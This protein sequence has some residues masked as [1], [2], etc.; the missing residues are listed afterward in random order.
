MIEMLIEDERSFKLPRIVQVISLSPTL[1]KKV[2]ESC[3]YRYWTPK[4]LL[5]T[6]KIVVASLSNYKKK[7]LVSS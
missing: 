3:T 1:L 2:T 4:L 5:Y 6:R 7:D